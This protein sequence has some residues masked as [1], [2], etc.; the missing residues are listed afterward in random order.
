MSQINSFSSR[1]TP[2]S[3]D[4]PNAY[5]PE[6]LI[7]PPYYW[8][9]GTET[10]NPEPSERADVWCPEFLCAQDGLEFV[11]VSFPVPVYASKVEIYQ[12][13]HPGSVVAIF[14]WADVNIFRSILK[15]III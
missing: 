9:T 5:S 14:A 12:N 3:S 4:L 8:I 2:S 15:L 11:D 10:P 6:H 13:Y 7:G 1:R